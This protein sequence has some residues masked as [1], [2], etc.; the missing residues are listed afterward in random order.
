MP[1][2]TLEQ[3]QKR[4]TQ[5]KEAIAAIGE[6]PDVAKTRELG[7]QLRR[8]QRLR[9]R[10]AVQAGRIAKAEEKAAAAKAAPAPTP[11]P[12]AE[13]AAAK[14]PAGETPAEEAPAE[15]TSE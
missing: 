4:E 9:R 5:V 14:A 1:A 3:A 12:V 11:A 2:R 7:K 10:L 15:E 13:P 6:A 8:A